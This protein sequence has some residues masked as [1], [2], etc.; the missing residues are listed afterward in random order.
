M[1]FSI[2]LSAMM[3]ASPA[4]ADDDNHTA[5]TIGW[6]IG[7]GCLRTDVDTMIKYMGKIFFQD[8]TEA[9]LKSLAGYV[10]SGKSAR[11]VYDNA[12]NICSRICS[13]HKDTFKRVD[14]YIEL[15]EKE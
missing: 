3:T 5:E 6:A 10:K 9:K 8:A 15:F 13:L 14:D 1:L 2:A 11:N 7:C 12:D 4:S